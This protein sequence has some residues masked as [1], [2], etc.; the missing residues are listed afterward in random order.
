M[1]T[2]HCWR[3]RNGIPCAYTVEKGNAVETVKVLSVDFFTFG[4]SLLASL[5]SMDGGC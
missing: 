2:W 1:V 5:C 3:V 4:G